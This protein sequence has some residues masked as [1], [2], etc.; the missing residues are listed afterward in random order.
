MSNEAA[1]YVDEERYKSI[2]EKREFTY[3]LDILEKAKAESGH[4]YDNA[5]EP[6]RLIWKHREDVSIYPNEL[7]PEAKYLG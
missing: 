7:W 5:E 6:I 3:K 2:A 4:V 1:K